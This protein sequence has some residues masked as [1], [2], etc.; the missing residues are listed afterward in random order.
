LIPLA[1][2]SLVTFHDADDWSLPDRLAIQVRAMRPRSVV[3]CLSSWIRLRADGTVVFFRQGAAVRMSVVSLMMSKE[4]CMSCGPFR[5]ARFGA[6]FEFY[7]K[8]RALYGDRR[9]ARIK[10]PLILALWSSSSLTRAA[11]CE[12]LETGYRSPARRAYCEIVSQRTRLGSRAIADADVDAL[13]RKHGNYLEPAGIVDLNAREQQ[14]KAPL[15]EERFLET[16]VEGQ[17]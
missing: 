8:L 14:Q 15:C 12:A 17:V 11:G 1:R 16:A 9:I 7:Q 4:L 5:S 2:G 6:D 10:A 13:L 3:A